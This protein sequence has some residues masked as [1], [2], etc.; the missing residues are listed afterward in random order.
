VAH[1]ALAPVV[2][3]PEAVAQIAPTLVE[4]SRWLWRGRK[5][6]CT[7]IGIET[8]SVRLLSKHMRGKALPYAP[9]EWSEIVTTAVGIL[10]DNGIFPLVTL[11]I[12]LPG[13]N[14]T[15]TLATLELLENLASA[16]LF[17]VPLLFTAEEECKLRREKEASICEINELQWDVFATCWRR[18]IAL[19]SESM[20][21]RL[22]MLASVLPSYYLYYRWKHGSHVIYP[23]LKV[24]GY[25]QSFFKSFSHR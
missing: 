18:N 17:Y 10:N 4:K 11:V 23:M 6:A 15:D 5:I 2:R 9:E 22:L 20:H 19:W 21:A 16:K 1:A 12:G 25:P 7:E 24:A 14:E 3:K 13:E 8:G